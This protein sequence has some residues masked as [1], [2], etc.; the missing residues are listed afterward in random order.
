MTPVVKT[1]LDLAPIGHVSV[2]DV[3]LS[4]Y[5]LLSWSIATSRSTLIAGQVVRWQRQ[6]LDVDDL[7][8]EIPE[9]PL[10]QCD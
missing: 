3:G 2:A 10:C 7:R 5:P 6:K 4:D 1:Q 9:S 8:P